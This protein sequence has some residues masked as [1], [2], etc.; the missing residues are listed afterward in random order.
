MAT[1]T[2][3]T[4]PVPFVGAWRRA[5]MVFDG[6]ARDDADVLWLQAGEWYAD[7]RIPLVDGGGAVE[8]FAGPA[9]WTDPVF[10]WTHE[11]DWLGT[12]AE[13]AGQL[14]RVPATGPVPG[15][16]VERGSAEVEGRTVDYVEEWV[17]ISPPDPPLLVAGRVDDAAGE[18]ACLVRVGAHA[19]VMVD[20]RPVGGGFGV[21]REEQVAGVW[22]M[23]FERIVGRL[24]GGSLVPGAGSHIDGRLRSMA[25]VGDRML[26]VLER[27]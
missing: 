17:I 19:L 25:S 11:L 13:D 4:T 3:T 16:L 5:S 26:P 7:L 9:T 21:R 20:A 18:R 27:G 23:V 24:P 1:V 10:T 14:E 22:T 6:V 12:F 15:T 2:A 8:A